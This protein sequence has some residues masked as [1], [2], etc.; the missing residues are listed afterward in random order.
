MEARLITLGAFDGRSSRTLLYND[1]ILRISLDQFLSTEHGSLYLV[2]LVKLEAGQRYW[3]LL[4]HQKPSNEAPAVPEYGRLGIVMTSMEQGQDSSSI[5]H[6]PWT[7][8]D[9]WPHV[10]YPRTL[11]QKTARS[12]TTE[13]FEDT[14]LGIL[15]LI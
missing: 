8:T 13:D 12:F 15:R 5:D 9:W 6:T 14:K 7:D 3:S 2:P 11:G 4:V 1:N 10:F